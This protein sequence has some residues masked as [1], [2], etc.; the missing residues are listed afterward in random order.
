MATG[1]NL[2]QDLLKT[3]VA[4]A[5]VVMMSQDFRE[6]SLAECKGMDQNTCFKLAPETFRCAQRE[7]SHMLLSSSGAQPFPRRCLF[8]AQR[9]E[10]NMMC[11][12][13]GLPTRLLFL[14]WLKMSMMHI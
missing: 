7:R 11:G 9:E 4:P 5:G 1:A 13:G 3:L 12:R 2:S 6:R 10:Q 8:E 14:S